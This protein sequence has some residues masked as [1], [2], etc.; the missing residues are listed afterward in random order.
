MITRECKT[1]LLAD[2]SIFFRTKL[3]TILTEAGHRVKFAR[4]G[5]EVIEEISIDP[6]GIDLLILD[7][8]MPEID[9]FGVLKWMR[10]K[11][12]LGKFPVLAITGVYESSEVLEKVRSAGADGLMTKGFS[13]EQVLYR[14][15]QL[16]FP[17]NT[18]QRATDRV[19]LSVPADFTVGERTFTGFLLNI[20][21][22]GLFLH[23]LEELL[24]GTVVHL[25]FSLPD[26]P[27]VIELQGVVRWTTHSNPKKHLFG[28]AG[29]MFT[30]VSEEDQKLIKEFVEKELRRLGLAH[31]Y[32]L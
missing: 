27:K 3:S 28:G 2:D 6:S 29:I 26:N 13:P 12:H 7:L 8:Q 25:K 1:I 15:H 19:P 20:S 17:E 14:V 5:K 30:H 11:G 4:D 10:E 9:G 24:P 18:A 23:T 32:L 21:P 31:R 16:L 22:N